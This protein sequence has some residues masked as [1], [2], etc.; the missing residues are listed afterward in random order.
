MRRLILLSLLTIP[1]LPVRADVTDAAENGFTSVNEVTI[2]STPTEAWLAATQQV[3]AWWNAD[4]TL[5]GDASRL[6]IEARPMGCFCESL[7]D[8]AGIVHLTVTAVSP[9]SLLR[10]TG[11]LGPL[12]VM[13]VDGNM[14]WEFEEA[15]N[16]TLIRFTYAVGGYAKD[17]LQ[18]LAGPVDRVVG[19]A[20][21]RL[22][23]FVETGSPLPD[24]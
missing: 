20:L 13:G 15:D 23:R 14:T 3:A 5:S 10:M 12:G 17:G 1:V 18:E 24:E 22:A 2:A 11:G 19:E 9:D 4:H 7:G 8:D 16:G 6:S 21:K